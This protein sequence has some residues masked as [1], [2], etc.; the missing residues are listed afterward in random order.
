MPDAK[1]TPLLSRNVLIYDGDTLRGTPFRGTWV[2]IPEE[3]FD[4]LRNA[5]PLADE[6]ADWIDNVGK[7]NRLIHEAFST[8]NL[9]TQWQWDDIL[10]KAR[11]Y[12][13]AMKAPTR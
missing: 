8:P 6:L 3:D 1:H 10:R 2:A 4:Q 12:Q 7:G 9:P 11:A 13:K 5:G